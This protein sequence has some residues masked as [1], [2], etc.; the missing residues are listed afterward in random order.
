MGHD[1]LFKDLLRTFF[2][3][4]LILFLPEIA[5]QLDPGAINF[6]DT[7][8]FTDLPEGKR[9]V[10]D[11]VAEVCGQG[12]EPEVVLIHTDVQAQRDST[13]DQRMWTTIRACGSA[14]ASR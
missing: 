8:T 11:L 7:E 10:A 5:A 3:D 4:F 14:K 6:L 2:H 13:L 1:Q 12:M 9:R